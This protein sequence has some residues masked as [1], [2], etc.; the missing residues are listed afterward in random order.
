L[1][2]ERERKNS[3]NICV[4]SGRVVRNAVIKGTDK[5]V[6]RFLVE[7]HDGHE[8]G[9][10]KERVNQVPCVCFGAST[11][12]EQV[13]AAGEGLRVEL[14]GRVASWGENN[15]KSGAEVLVFNRSMTFVRN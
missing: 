8:E 9:D 15:G 1:P 14:Q 11:E 7:T 13:L 4:I 10:I 2:Q 5:K 3:M 6:L 12:L